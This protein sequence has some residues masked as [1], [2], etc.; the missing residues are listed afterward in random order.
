MATRLVVFGQAGRNRQ[1][2]RL[3]GFLRPASTRN[4]TVESTLSQLATGRVWKGEWSAVIGTALFLDVRAGQFAARRAERPNGSSPRT[5]DS[6]LPAVRGG[7][8][9]WAEELR[10]DQMNAAV[11]YFRHGRLGRHHFK[12][13]VQLHRVI[14]AETW[15]HA[16]P[17]D[18]LHVAASGLPSEVY[19]FQ[20]PSRSGE[21]AVVVRGSRRRYMADRRASDDQRRC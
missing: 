16:Y 8:R 2:I 14:T 4:A 15:V 1:P 3:N 13:G 9:N 10:N 20:T 17:G 7:N 11:S 19:L 12:A 18:V 6:L 21:R 5:E